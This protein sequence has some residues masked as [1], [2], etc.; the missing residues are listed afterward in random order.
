LG[1]PLLAGALKL[2]KSSWPLFLAMGYAAYISL[3]IV[4][5]YGLARGIDVIIGRVTQK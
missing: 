4:I 3:A 5:S 2:G 1:P